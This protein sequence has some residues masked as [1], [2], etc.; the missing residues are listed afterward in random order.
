MEEALLE[1]GVIDVGV[2]TGHLLAALKKCKGSILTNISKI[3]QSG[4][5]FLSRLCVQWHGDFERRQTLPITRSHLFLHEWNKKKSVALVGDEIYVLWKMWF[6]NFNRF[7]WNFISSLFE[8]WRQGW[9][10][11]IKS[12]NENSNF[13]KKFRERLKFASQKLKTIIKAVQ[14]WTTPLVQTR[15]IY[16]GLGPSLLGFFLALSGFCQDD[17]HRWQNGV[18]CSLTRRETQNDSTF[19]KNPRGK[20]GN[21]TSTKKKKWRKDN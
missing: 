9:L 21:Q 12:S 16:F 19:K 14:W 1:E 6:E 5:K 7:D 2:V 4:E 13:K 11:K 17:H 8:Q 18:A 15:R 10:V 3:R 20:K